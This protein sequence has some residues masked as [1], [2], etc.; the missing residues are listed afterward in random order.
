MKNQVKEK[1]PTPKAAAGKEPVKKA[2]AHGERKEG[3]IAAT[4]ATETGVAKVKNTV[5]AVK[6]KAIG[7]NHC[8]L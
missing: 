1:K 8:L 6:E 5:N 7:L 4:P 2:S 3:K